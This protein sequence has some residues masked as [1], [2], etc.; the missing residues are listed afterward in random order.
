MAKARIL[1]VDDQRYF[2]EL[3]AGLLAE[4]GYATETA[5]SGEEALRILDRSDFDVVLTD[6]VMPGMDGS[7]LVR[8]VKQRDPDQD[9]IVVTGV[10]DV[11]TAV[12]AMKLGASDY[13]LKPF[14]RRALA[15][16]LEGTLGRRRVRAERDRLL[17][18]NIE[19]ITETRLL[20]RALALF[21]AL[22]IDALA[23]RL[24]R[25]LCVETGAQGAALWVA[26]DDSAER[27]EL[28]AVHG[29]VRVAEEPE[30][31]EAA[32]IPPEL[33]DEDTRVALVA[34]GDASQA[35]ALCAV[36]RRDA[37]RI[38]LV[39][40]TDRL[41]GERFE[42]L[43]RLAAERLVRHAEVALAHALR[44]RALERRS[45]E[46]PDTG[47]WRHE[48][49]ADVAR[50]ELEK[51]HRF[52][53]SLALLAI[54]PGWPEAAP[55]SRE[56]AEAVARA[57]AGVLRATDL[58]AVDGAGRFHVL[59]AE[60]DALGAAVFK[61]RCQQALARCEALAALPER[62]RSRPRL[63][64]ASYPGDGGQLEALERALEA[65]LEAGRRSIVGSLSLE[66]LSLG[67]A[68]RAL[69]R[70]GVSARSETPAEIARF[71][72]EECGRRPRER[73]LVYVV[74]GAALAEPVSQA[75]AALRGVRLRSEIA[76]LGGERPPAES[77]AGAWV[78]PERVTTLPPCLVHYGDGA[79]YAMVRAPLDAS[80]ATRLFHSSD[81]ELA[82]YLAFRLHAELSL[83]R[84][85]EEAA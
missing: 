82:E 45:F 46:D 51:A 81:R 12:E 28:A 54:D 79:A 74:P 52:G 18:E 37:Q 25:A 76:V 48:F 23:P 34:W 55:R 44:V 31:V 26:A 65:R 59:L 14:D 58:L 43:D 72:L 19:Y 53:R 50:G 7:E 29:L 15:V 70:E 11:G 47:V 20:E 21:S 38:G 8:R 71:V 10:V 9:V 83:P 67:D 13:L 17:A 27:L 36:L 49:L 68:L 33:S 2:R 3:I 35:P 56:T 41:E 84:L 40:L 61:R 24:L 16:T 57:L 1:A 60:C 75:L 62:G 32:E 6:L 80:G 4:E 22:S 73:S 66:K 42:E 39:R 77:P 78:A 64:S 69:L 63:A 5:S 85:A 30:S